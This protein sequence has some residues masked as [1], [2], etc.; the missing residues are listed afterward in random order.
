[1]LLAR[2][3]NARR[4]LL[5]VAAPLTNAAAQVQ[6]LVL[7]QLRSRAMLVR[8]HVTHSSMN[9]RQRKKHRSGEY[10]ELGFD[11][12]FCTPAGWTESQQREF[13]DVVIA[14]IEALGLA[15]GGGI[16]A[17]WDV[18]VTSRAERGS[19]TPG[20]RLAIAEWLAAQTAISGLRA[21]PLVDSWHTAAP[22]R[23]A[24]T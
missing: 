21:G 2:R 12:R 8:S 13:F 3:A 7:V 19:V 14:R 17:C 11:L 20:Q 24:A 22:V 18:F 6:Y 5:P 4:S 16:G 23:G 1:M 15:V 10:Q 9:E